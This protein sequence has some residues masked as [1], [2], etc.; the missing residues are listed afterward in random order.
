MTH[1]LNSLWQGIA[2]TAIV[3]L[4]LRF[5]PRLSAA[6]RYAIW[7]VAMLAVV[8][9]PLAAYFPRE[10]PSTAAPTIDSRSE[11]R[12]EVWASTPNHPP[13]VLAAPTIAPPTQPPI[14]AA[15]ATVPHSFSIRLPANLATRVILAAWIILSIALL[16]RLGYSFQALRRLKTTAVQPSAELQTRFEQIACRARLN[17]RAELLV[18]R[19]ITTPLALGF[20]RPAIIIPESIADGS[21][22]E[23]FDNLALHELAHLARFDDWTNLLQQLLIALFPIQPALFW[24]S[25]HINLEREAACDDRVVAI[26]AAPKPY[27]ASLTRIAELALWSRSAI[28]ATGVASGR[29]QLYRRIHRLLDGH[30][31]KLSS[32]SP[33]PLVTAIAIIASLFILSFASPQFIA[34]AEDVPPAT[35]PSFA[36]LPSI[37]DLAAQ[38]LPPNPGTQTVSIPAN[39][40]EKLVIDADLGNFTLKSW[41]Q[42][43][44]EFKITQKGSGI[45]RYL[46][47]H[48]VTI[49][50]KGHEVT[51]HA[52]G[53]GSATY[54]GIEVEYEITVPK[55]FDLLL[56]NRSG[57]TDISDLTGSLTA[58]IDAGNID[59]SSC[60]GD[61][62]ATT[63][64]GNVNLEKLTA[65]AHATVSN[66]NVEA[67]SC[68][69]PLTLSTHAGNV[70][71]TQCVADVVA[72]TDAGN[73][74]ATGHSGP[75]K[76]ESKM[77]NVEVQQFTGSSLSASTRMG[78]VE[79]EIDATPKSSCS[80]TTDMGNADVTLIRTAAVTL[81]FRTGMGNASSDF[82]AGPLNG[83]GPE[84][85]VS[86]KMGNISISKK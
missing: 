13:I 26:T 70:D 35:R 56:D 45:S 12:L 1:L 20:V 37:P 54:S 16:T 40:G 51:L 73:V 24:I 84:I 59:I 42:S 69:S 62:D 47:Q 67:D 15:A 11:S 76:A 41:D 21:S 63:K 58:D 34:L 71:V 17:R 25:R 3:W 30:T 61:I 48:H 7:C 55:N 66:G 23:E 53:E 31:R 2:L 85:Q 81:K 77:G 28:L 5:A 10:S 29:S 43:S 72:G 49:G 9:L 19:E 36:G 83:G 22:R 57:N 79:A 82:R 4:F 68:Q 8:L 75:L 86:T 39:P 78:N 64:A 18:S 80:V 38:T 27:A 74:T 50:R 52:A 44:V 46:Q 65:T 6:T 14:T 32:L 33:I 60:G